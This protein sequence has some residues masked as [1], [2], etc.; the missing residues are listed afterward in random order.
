ML[1]Q[2]YADFDLTRSS[3]Q[4]KFFNVKTLKGFQM[5]Y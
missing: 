4:C 5:S 1:L 3:G 2:I